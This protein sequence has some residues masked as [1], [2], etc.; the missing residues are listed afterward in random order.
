MPEKALAVPLCSEEIIDIAV[1]EFRTRLRQLSP[2]QLN[3]EY[4]AF[5][6]SFNHVIRLHRMASNGGGT[7]DTLA[8]VNTSKGDLTV[9]KEPDQ[10]IVV[11]DVYTSGTDVNQIRLDHDLPLTVEAGDGKGG[12]V[13]KKVKIAKEKAKAS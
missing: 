2:L 10:T 8:W 3:K 12:K 5:E 1:Q 6:I 7:T 13:R 9:D 4:L 11:N